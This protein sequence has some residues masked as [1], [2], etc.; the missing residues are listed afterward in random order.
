MEA[1][2]A[3]LKHQEQRQAY[4]EGGEFVTFKSMQLSINKKNLNDL[5]MHTKGNLNKIFWHNKYAHLL[6]PKFNPW[7][8]QTFTTNPNEKLANSFLSNLYFLLKSPTRHQIAWGK[9]KITYARK[10]IFILDC[11][12]TKYV[13]PTRYDRRWT[14]ILWRTLAS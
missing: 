4:G 12:S 14:T 1:C 7:I 8:L 10:L 2:W 11:V 6:A 3:T 13:L 9:I 5:T